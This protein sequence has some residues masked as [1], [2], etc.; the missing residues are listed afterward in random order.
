[1][2]RVPRVKPLDELV[3][4]RYVMHRPDNVRRRFQTVTLAAAAAA[5]AVVVA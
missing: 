3:R 5:A 2:L 4:L 1:M